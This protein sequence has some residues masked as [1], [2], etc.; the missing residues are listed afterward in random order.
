MSWLKKLLRISDKT[1]NKRNAS[2]PRTAGLFDACMEKKTKHV[3]VA[4][5]IGTYAVSPFAVHCRH[6]VDESEMDPDDPYME[7]LSEHGNQHE[8]DVHE[9]RYPDAK[10]AV[11]DTPE[12]GFMQSIDGM[13]NGTVALLGYDLFYLPLGL[14]GKPDVLEKAQ[15]KSD[16]GDYHYIVKE[17][18]LARNIKKSHI[19]QAAFY[20]LMIGKIQG[21]VPDTF[22]L[23]NMDEEEFGFK[24]ADY[25]NELMAAIDGVNAIRDGSV[26]SPVYGS[27]PYPWR[28]YSDK[29][30]M[31][32]RDISLV[33]GIGSEKRKALEGRGLTTI[34][35]L[36]GCDVSDLVSMKGI[37][38]KTATSYMLSAKA[39][40]SGKPVRKSQDRL[41]LP[42]T[43][44]EIF[45][46]LEGL[47]ILNAI[48]GS[49]QEKPQTDYLIGVLVRSNGKE[50]YIGFVAHD[51]DSEEKMLLEFLDFVKNQKDYAIYHWHHYERTHLSKMMD[52][53]GIEESVRDLVLSE[54]VMFD[55]HK[56]STALYAFPVPGTSIKT[57]A[58]W[59]GFEWKHQDVGAMS[60]IIL[61][62]QYARNNKA[63]RDK[64]EM[65]LDYNRDDCKA[66]VI[67]KD[68]LVR[69]EVAGQ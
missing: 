16:F 37:G 64:L 38:K 20:N 18:K 68:W 11:F 2:D 10:P 63:N 61:Y 50:R 49:E 58:K 27:G 21:Y 14:K 69:Q 59:M 45:L 3:V 66:T 8:D 48:S 29:K 51:A 47:D 19:L 15:G 57:I 22:Y 31:E 36:A 30:A 53:Y 4:S 65:V 24:F 1:E 60:S 6:F 54:S 23:I 39:M 62:Q 42:N 52:L 46:D 17:I 13:V 41:V 56:I 32:S 34:D 55:L 12:D 25:E 33:S 67:I 5:E 35:D 40:V 28:T 7:Q 43:E 44:T 26:P 9:H